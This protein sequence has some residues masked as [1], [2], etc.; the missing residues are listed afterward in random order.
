MSWFASG[1]DLGGSLRNPASWCGVVG[2]R[3]TSGLI[4]HGPSNFPFFNL[5][6]DGPMARN[7]KD[8]IAIISKLDSIDFR[9]WILTT[10]LCHDEEY[11]YQETKWFIFGNGI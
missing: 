10:K 1:S 4:P 8:C 9:S 6:V 7:I 11:N 3:P 5:S 2:L